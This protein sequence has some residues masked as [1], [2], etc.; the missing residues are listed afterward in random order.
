MTVVN[1]EESK[2]AQRQ[3]KNANYIVQ[4]TRNKGRF[5]VPLMVIL[6]YKGFFVAARANVHSTN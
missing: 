4:V 3:F 2:R 5:R 1:A 6:E